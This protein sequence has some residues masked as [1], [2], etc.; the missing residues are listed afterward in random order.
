MATVHPLRVVEHPAHDSVLG[1]LADLGRLEIELGLA[2]T[3]DVLRSAL[4]AAGVA[5]LAIVALIASLVV[6]LAGVIAPAFGAPW[7][8]LVASGGA[9]LVITVVA[10]AWSAR[11]LRSLEWPHETLTSLRE[12]WRWLGTQLRS[13]LT[14]R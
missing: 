8:H 1:R 4:I 6:L 10:L 5:A 12:N 14:S 7:A 13:R 2:E 9:V 3:R 11:R